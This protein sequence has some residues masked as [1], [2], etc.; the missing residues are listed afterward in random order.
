M[1]SSDGTQASDDDGPPRRPRDLSIDTLRGLAVLLMVTA[2]TIGDA[3]TR[4]LRVTPGSVYDYIYE[5]TFY[6]RLPLFTVISG[7]VYAMRPVRPG[8]AWPFW[9]G[10]ARR[11]LWPYLTVASLYFVIQ[12]I[13][14]G[15][16]EARPWSAMWE[17]YVFGY[18]HFWYLQA[19][20]VIFLLLPVLDGTRLLY[21]F[22][23]WAAAVLAATL[24]TLLTVGPEGTRTAL[25]DVLDY[26]SLWGTLRLLPF[27][28]VG[29]GVNR[30]GD[31][32]RT[33][34]LVAV[35]AVIGVVGFI[36][37]QHLFLTDPT[38]TPDAA[39]LLGLSYGLATT[40]LLMTFRRAW[41][42][43]AVIGHYSFAIYLLHVFGT[44]GCRVIATRLGIDDT[45]TLLVLCV[46]C[47]VAGPIVAQLVVSPYKWLRLPLLGI[48]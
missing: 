15:A 1:E 23:T 46:A 11:L 5:L 16:N 44:A 39:G 24:L 37:Q 25:S 40:G 9:R 48:K 2:H 3:P 36:A 41:K 31:R 6:L 42:P 14:P 43:L 8:R 19:L 7:Y 10:K 28:I 22:E 4:G 34:W 45:A 47:G 30:F 32:L 26:F 20:F 18:D 27:F 17:I 13:V 33:R 12:K 38:A 35:A 29:I 21:K